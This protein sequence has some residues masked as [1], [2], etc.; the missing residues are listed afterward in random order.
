MRGLVRKRGRSGAAKAI[1]AGGLIAGTLDIASAYISTL[2]HAGVPMRMLQ[3]IAYAAMGPGAMKGGWATA[4]L[5][6]ALHFVIALGAAAVYY[7]ASRWLSVM[8]RE[9]VVSGLLYGV[10]VFLTMNFI[11]VPLS[12]IGRVLP[13]T[14]EA[15]AIGL[16]IL[17]MCVGLPIALMTRR[18]AG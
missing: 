4:G 1:L 3:G 14:M 5:G 9:P 13:G 7:A 15:A 2:I 11:I 8:V 18:Y 17:M 10:L 16:V 6:L 12:R